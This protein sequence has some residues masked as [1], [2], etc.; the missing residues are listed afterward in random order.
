METCGPR[1]FLLQKTSDRLPAL[2]ANRQHIHLFAICFHLDVLARLR[3]VFGGHQ[4]LSITTA[5]QLRIVKRDFLLSL[6]HCH[7]HLLRCYPRIAHQARSSY[8]SDDL[9]LPAYIRQFPYDCYPFR[10]GSRQD[11]GRNQV[12]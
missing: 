4:A 7:F 8:C 10:E 6:D 5:Q 9:H 3:P 12:S 1:L 2:D 11:Q